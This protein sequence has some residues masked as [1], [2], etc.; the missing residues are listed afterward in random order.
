M[1]K[2]VGMGR[3]W[4]GKSPASTAAGNGTRGGGCRN[5]RGRAALFSDRSGKELSF[6]RKKTS[7][8]VCDAADWCVCVC[9]SLESGMQ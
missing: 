1:A 4:G 3:G 2:V 8:H 6:S 5:G 9:D 7:V